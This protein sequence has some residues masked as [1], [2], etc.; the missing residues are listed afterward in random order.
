M[1]VQGIG[2]GSSPNDGN[3]DSLLAGALKIN[4]NFD[5]LYTLLGDG[6]TLTS[7][8]VNELVAGS[9]VSLSATTGKVTIN[10]NCICKRIRF[11]LE[12]YRRRKLIQFLTLELEA[13]VLSLH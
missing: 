6:A 1:A 10:A 7:N 9:N 13:L 12:N 4:S 3:G 8:V 5:E 11:C 2:T